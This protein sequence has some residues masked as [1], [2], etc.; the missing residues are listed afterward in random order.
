[1]ELP[2]GRQAYLF[3]VH[4]AHAPYQPY[5]LL[6]IPYE[7]APF[8]QTS[9][10]AVEAA[11][12]AR[13]SQVE[14]L[15]AEVS[16]AQAEGLPMFLTGDFNEPSHR[17]W[18]ADAVATSQCP[19]SVEWPATKAVE[20]AGFSDAFRSTHPDPLLRPGRTWTP[21]T[22]PSDPK[23]RHD[24][25]DFVFVHGT[26]ARVKATKTIG[27]SQE[28]ADIVVRPYPSDHRAVVAEFELAPPRS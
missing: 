24:R 5:Q 1:L 19:L 21:I 10:Q 17:D 25:I 16:A 14:R 7:D 18:T 12:A 3:N 26:T 22:K 9:E 28:F 20:S 4:F 8:L 11:R 23:D 2:S 6:G 27:E 13:G 15:L